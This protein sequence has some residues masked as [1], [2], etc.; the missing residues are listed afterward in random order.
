M[1]LLVERGGNL[2][3]GDRTPL[4]ES[5]SEG[6]ADLVLYIV[7]QLK[8]QVDNVAEIIKDL[9]NALLAA[10]EAGNINICNI[11]LENGADVNDYGKDGRTALMEAAKQGN[12]LIVEFLIHKGAMVNKISSNNDATA[13]SLGCLDYI[14]NNNF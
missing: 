6:H 3:I 9:N 5:A 2:C 11:L 7:L 12:L 10:T 8:R 4:F 14:N 13:L 1:E